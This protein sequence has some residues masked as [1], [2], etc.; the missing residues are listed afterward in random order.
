MD[1]QNDEEYTKFLES[2]SK[3]LEL[4]EIEYELCRRDPY[5]WLT[6]WVYTV[7]PH[8]KKTPI[9]R[10]PAK[11]HIKR[12]VEVWL[13]E[14]LILVPK[15][16]QMMVSWLFCSLYLWDTQFLPGRLNFFQSKKEEDADSLIRRAKF[17]YDSQPKFIRKHKVN[18]S[19][20]GRHIYCK[21]EIPEIQ[22]MIRGIPQG[23]DQIRMHTASGVFSDEMAFQP[24]AEAAYT[25]AKPTIDGGGRW[26]GVSSAEPGFFAD[27]V[28]D[29][30]AIE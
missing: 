6:T 12:L 28:D 30:V 20:S 16:R 23:G 10:F 4:Q 26:T 25:A 11:P 1:L 18:P 13:D 7:D 9:K 3:S 19:N 27:M 15:S 8:D 5:H 21:F 14:P 17:I 22:S 2:L 29:M 24:E